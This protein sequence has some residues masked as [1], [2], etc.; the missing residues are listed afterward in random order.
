MKMNKEF[1]LKNLMGI[2]CA[3]IILALFLPFMSVKA[4]VSV[5]GFGGGSADQSMNGFS[6]VTDGGFFGFAFI[7]CLVAVAASCYIPQLKPFRKIIS[8]IGSVAGIV[9]LFIAPG[10][11][12]SAVNAAAGGATAGTGVSAKVELNYLIGFWIILILMLALIAMS[13][14]Q[15]L[16]LKGNKVFD[17]VNSAEDENGTAGV[18]LPSI[19]TDGIKSAIGSVNADSIKNMAQNAAGSIAGAAGNLKDKASQAAANMQNHLG[20]ASAP[21][22]LE[23]GVVVAALHIEELR[24]PLVGLAHPFQRTADLRLEQHDQRQQADLQQR[25]EQPGDRAHVEHVRHQIDGQ[26]QQ[27]AL[28]QLPG[29][30]AVDN[31]QQLIDQKRDDDDIQKVRQL[32]RLEIRDDRVQSHESF[33]CLQRFDQSHRMNGD[34]QPLAGKAQMLF[35]GGLD[36]HGVQRHPE[37]F[38]QLF[39][40]GGDVG[41]QLRLLAEDGGIDVLD[42]PAVLPDDAGHMAGQHQAVSPGIF[43]VGIREVL[44]DVAQSRCA[45]HSVHDGVGQHVGVGMAQ[46]ALLIR[47]LHTAQDQLAALHETMNIITMTN[48]HRFSFLLLRAGSKGMDTVGAMGER[49]RSASTTS[50][51]VRAG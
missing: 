33:S 44:P 46:Q 1:I 17:A 6:L 7:L 32:E 23:A 10:S 48:A 14:I 12:A 28:G 18:S 50:R 19:N 39:A 43:G 3:V 40:H 30:G 51:A 38:G 21:G 15:F 5:G 36:A 37:G 8:A 25:V 35:G 16:G 41:S 47:D 9:C 34:A 42:L 11:A 4:E 49:P 13:V 20:T 26:H 31:A 24:G 45:Q 27:G 22:P 2:I 29:A